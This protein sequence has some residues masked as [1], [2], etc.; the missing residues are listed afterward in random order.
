MFNSDKH[1]KGNYTPKNR[2][3]YI[4]NITKINYR[5]HWEL[6]TMR[7]LDLNPDIKYWSSEETIVRYICPTDNKIHNYIIDFTLKYNNGNILLVEVKPLKQTILPKQTKGKSKKSYLTEALAFQ[8][9]KSKWLAA[10]AYAQQNN[11]RFV[12]WSEVQLRRFGIPIL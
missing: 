2:S 3:K 8:K 11:A 6:L 1:H 4:G 9:N 10:H 12:I 7:Y 5:S